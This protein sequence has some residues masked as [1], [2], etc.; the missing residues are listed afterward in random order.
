MARKSNIVAVWVAY[1]W[2]VMSLMSCSNDKV[3]KEV[4]QLP[5]IYPDYADV[6]IPINIAPLNFLLRDS[7]EGVEVYADGKRMCRRAGSEVV[8]KENEW[9]TL[10]Q[11]SVGKDIE[12]KVRAEYKDFIAEY[13]AFKWTV[14]EDS[15]DSY[16]TYRLIEPD[17]EVFSRLTMEERCV[18][19]FEKRSFCDY[20]RVGNRCMNCHAYN[21]QDPMLSM[22]YVRGKNG[23]AVLNRNGDLSILD[24]NVGGGEGGSVYFGFHPDG[25]YIVFSSN[26]IIPAFHSL[27]SRRLEVYDDVSDIYV[28]DLD[29]YRIYTND[30]LSDSLS[31][32]TFPTF[33]P[34]GKYVY[35][36]TAEKVRLPEEVE[37]LQYR[38]CRISFDN[39]VLGQEVDTLY[40][41]GTSVCHPKVSPDGRYLLYTVQDYGTFPIWHREADLRM[42]DLCTGE[43]DSLEVV[44]SD[45]SD[46]YHCWS[47]NSRWFVFASKRDDGLYGKPYFSYVDR[48][49]K[50][51]KPFVLPQKNPQF[52]DNCLKSFNIPEL[53]CGSLPFNAE[54]VGELMH[55]F[56]PLRF[57]VGQ[58]TSSL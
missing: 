52:Y 56:S 14:V 13:A 23:G 31:L 26:H 43:V 38:L 51:H 46:T 37:D 5:P 58:R 17:Y 49:G 6:T 30:L 10:L 32:E 20:E 11:N 40:K 47:S 8:F 54:D 1:V 2:V 50:A 25:R 4:S 15:I 42:M 12:V 29:E 22:L 19:N 34:D 45:R 39:G 55:S 16:L 44:N 21:R 33:S 35:F 57:S 27:G 9:R 24:L 28:A 36:C 18:E 3:V 7:V 48:E 41:A 53:G